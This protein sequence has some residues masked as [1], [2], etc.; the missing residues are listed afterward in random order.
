MI[1]WVPTTGRLDIIIN[2]SYN[3]TLVVRPV[4]N[5]STHVLCNACGDKVRC[6]LLDFEEVSSSIYRLASTVDGS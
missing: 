6:H 1:K 4:E 5:V 3:M 2:F